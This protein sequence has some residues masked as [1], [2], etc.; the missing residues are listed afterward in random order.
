M[1]LSGLRAPRR[2]MQE[3]R[4]KQ[5]TARRLLAAQGRAGGS[6]IINLIASVMA[7]GGRVCK[8]ASVAVAI[9]M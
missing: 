9:E 8:F 1:V 6:M 2:M 4:G 3:S 5:S 7:G